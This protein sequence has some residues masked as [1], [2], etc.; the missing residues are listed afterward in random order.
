MNRPGE[1]TGKGE[2]RTRQLLHTL[3]APIFTVAQRP[4]FMP[5]LLILSERSQAV[6]AHC[7]LRSLFRRAKVRPLQ[8]SEAGARALSAGTRFAL[9]YQP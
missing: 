5:A 8:V 3:P 6:G 7:A 1:D 4:P 9:G 2:G